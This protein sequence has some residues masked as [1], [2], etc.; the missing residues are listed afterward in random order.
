[1]GHVHSS[2]AA[3]DAE[4]GLEKKPAE[5]S[6]LVP[7]PDVS[8]G[9]LDAGGEIP[10]FTW[11]TFGVLACMGLSWVQRGGTY[12]YGLSVL[13]AYLNAP[14]NVIAASYSIEPSPQMLVLVVGILSDCNPVCGSRRKFYAFVGAALVA[15]GYLFLL[16]RPFPEPY[17]CSVDPASPTAANATRAVC[18]PGAPHEAGVIIGMLTYVQTGAVVLDAGLAGLIL[19][20]ARR[21]PIAT[22][23]RV[24]AINAI[25]CLTGSA[26]GSLFAKA[27]ADRAE[28]EKDSTKEDEEAD[29]PTSTPLITLG[30]FRDRNT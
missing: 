4:T 6:P 28:H 11:R 2:N 12:S 24:F 21:E 5:S 19:D 8:S 16:L 18:N 14:A 26:L 10:L 25:F 3:T 9:A 29:V 22:R 27:K 1:M 30:V 15:S 13:Q 7:P 20:Y 23:G 17:Y